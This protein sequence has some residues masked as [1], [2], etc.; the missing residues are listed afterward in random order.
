MLIEVERH[1]KD[2]VLKN[3]ILFFHC[4]NNTIQLE[5][6]LYQVHTGIEPQYQLHYYHDYNDFKKLIIVLLHCCFILT[7]CD[8]L[9]VASDISQRKLHVFFHKTSLI[10]IKLWAISC[11]VFG[12]QNPVCRTCFTGINK[13]KS[14]QQD[15]HCEIIDATYG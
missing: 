14:T 9:I 3:W 1:I 11:C 10:K 4:N 2:I 8:I 12:I 15:F 13:N 7:I 5:N 6:F